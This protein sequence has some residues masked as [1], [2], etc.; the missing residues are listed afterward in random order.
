MK[1]E[2]YKKVYVRSEADLPKEGNFIT[3][4]TSGEVEFISF[5]T[6]WEI[7]KIRS[8]VTKVT[9]DWY[10]LPIE[11]LPAP[12]TDEMIK[13]HAK[14]VFVLANLFSANP[15]VAKSVIPILEGF[16][17]DGA[18]WM[19]DKLS[20]PAPVTDAENFTE[21]LT[22]GKINL[23]DGDYYWADDKDGDFPMD[24]NQVVKAW[25]SFENQPEKELD[26]MG[27]LTVKRESGKKNIYQPEFAAR[28]N[29]SPTVQP[30]KKSDQSRNPTGPVSLLARTPDQSS[31]SEENG[32]TSI[33]SLKRVNTAHEISETIQAANKSMEFILA[34]ERGYVLEKTKGKTWK[35]RKSFE[36]TETAVLLADLCVL[37]FGEPAKKDLALWHQEIEAWVAHGVRPSDWT[38]MLEIISEYSTPAMSITG[39]SKAIKFA[40]TERREK[41]DN[42]T[43]VR[44]EH[45]PVQ[46]KT[47]NFVPPPAH[48]GKP[49]SVSG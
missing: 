25:L 6:I 39:I 40:A 24:H 31:P 44:P 12:V 27:Y 9:I 3:H 46:E 49:G 7:F 48:L 32:D 15:D 17:I 35:H 21:F 4:F 36:T 10:L 42:Q 20:N 37:K 23:C 45:K 22:K 16:Y 14:E 18:K 28:G 29:G 43:Y 47:G 30:V 11:P 5:K 34:A 33:K 8:K 1:D 38:R 41:K 19:R 26:E 2:T 13:E